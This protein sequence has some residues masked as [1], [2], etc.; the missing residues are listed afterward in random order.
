MRSD[1][2][3]IGLPISAVD[4]LQEKMHR[5]LSQH[6]LDVDGRQRRGD[7]RSQRDVVA[8]DDGTRAT[9][10]KKGLDTS[11]TTNPTVCVRWVARLRAMMSLILTLRTRLPPA[12]RKR[13]RKR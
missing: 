13:S 3:G 12:C 7:Q 5:L 1:H 11:G 4:H 9:P 8:A 10:A 6:V 2:D